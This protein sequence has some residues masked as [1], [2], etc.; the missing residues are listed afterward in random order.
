MRE[1][2]AQEFH[3]VYFPL[4]I[5]A[6]AREEDR[7]ANPTDC[8]SPTARRTKYE[9]YRVNRACCFVQH[10]CEHSHVRIDVTFYDAVNIWLNQGVPEW[11]HSLQRFQSGANTKDKILTAI[12]FDN[13]NVIWRKSRRLGFVNASYRFSP[14]H[15]PLKGFRNAKLKSPQM[16]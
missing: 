5:A 7:T 12:E 3:G 9:A 16:R 11:I 15:R 1:I 10:S 14:P 8:R 2:T 4:R 13:L 6:K